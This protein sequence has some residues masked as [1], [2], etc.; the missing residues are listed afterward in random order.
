MFETEG[1]AKRFFVEKILQ[2]AELEKAELTPAERDMLFWSETDPEWTLSPEQADAL[3]EQL[4][5]EI[6][7]ED[8]EE[9]ISGFLGRSYKRD[10]SVDGDRRSV[11]KKA[12]AKLNEGDH[13]IGVMVDTALA[14]V[15]GKK[16]SFLS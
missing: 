10:V 7:D 15:L 13:Y 1:D 2:Q 3:V 14:G 5:L 8:Y 12:Y 11:W 6:S 9:K 4:E 16:R